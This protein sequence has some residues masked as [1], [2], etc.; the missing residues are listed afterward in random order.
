[1]IG[2]HTLKITPSLLK[3][4]CDLDQFKGLWQGLERHTTG[5]HL[6]ADVA[7][8]GT[9]FEQLLAPLQGSPITG[10]QLCTLHAHLGKLSPPSAYKTR[11]SPL[12][13]MKGNE[14]VGTLETALP[15][16]VQGLMEKLLIWL[17][18]ALQEEE[19]HPL[20]VLAVFSAVFLQIAPFETG[21]IK[22]LHFLILLVLLK[23]GYTYAPYVPLAPLFQ[24]QAHAFWTA[25]HENQ[26]S[27]ETGS[28]AW[29]HWTG[30]FLGLLQVQKNSLLQ[31]LYGQETALQNLPALS[32]K[33]MGLFKQHQRLQM[34]QIV[35]L[36]NGRRATLKL[37][38]AELVDAGYL[39][40][41]GQ[42]RATWYSLV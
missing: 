5:L 38:L 41:Y 28:P 33:I 36:T 26:R 19:W 23:K 3:Q 16:D 29:E 42:A 15:E 39:R 40:R 34:K 2:M 22:L 30:F 31:K 18:S 35:S 4:L 9:G 14:A 13:I 11:S 25:L 24:A 27:L 10:A 12:T 21:N 6:L 37:R 8:Y 20:L 17:E 1:M 7:D 32:A